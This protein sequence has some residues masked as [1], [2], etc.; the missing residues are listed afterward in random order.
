M[1][2]KKYHELLAHLPKQEMTVL[3]GARQTGK[4]TLLR[5]IA[6]ALIASGEAMVLLSL[7]RK[8]VL[9]DLDRNPE[10]IFKYLPRQHEGRMFALI[11][12]IQYLTDPTHFLKLLYDEHAHRL[13]IVATGS[14]AFY[15]D[16]QFKDSLAGRKKIFELQTL[17]FEEFLMFR[18]QAQELREL[19]RLRAG[20]IEKSTAAPQLWA[21]LETYLIY[22]GYPAV[23]LEDDPKHRIERLQELK[24]SF[25]KRDMLES[26]ITDETKFY[27]FMMLLAAQVGN[28]INIQELSNTLQIPRSAADHFLYVLQ[29]CFH[30]SLARPFF[31]N[32]RKELVKMPKGY[33]QDLGLRNALINYFA[34]LEQRPD[35]GALLENYVFRR[36]TEQYATHQIKFWRTADGNEVDFVVEE[37][38]FGGK[39]VEVKFNPKEANLNKYQKFT[40]AYPQYPLSFQS[41]GET[42][43]LL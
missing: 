38:A 24:D 1:L 11:D 12:E 4:S 25:V 5:Q 9:L 19:N 28:L 37:N 7:E 23:V 3:I 30:L 21:A 10:H 32:L 42:P 15:I 6:D 26:G 22:G 33:F 13:K 31:Q 14:S 18:N 27:R 20:E 2:R 41:W 16:R 39:A 35:K 40:S 36:L 8:D 17:D 43:L 34:P 29:K